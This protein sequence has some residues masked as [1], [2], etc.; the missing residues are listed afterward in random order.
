MLPHPL[1]NFDTQKNY[2]NEP[3]LSFFEVYSR[4]NLLKR[5]KDGAHIV[6]LDEYADFVTQWIALYG[7]NIENIFFDSFRVEHVPEKNEKFIEHKKI[8]HI[9]SKA[10]NSIMCCFCIGFIDFMLTFKTLI[11]YTNLFS[12][13]DFETL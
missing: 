10:N 4:D 3:R 12:P 1:K 8:K 6:N 5:I 7:K 13:Y 9:Q 11:D 2:Q